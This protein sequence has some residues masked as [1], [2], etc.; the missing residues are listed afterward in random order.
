[1]DRNLTYSQIVKH[2]TKQDG[3]K[4]FLMSLNGDFKKISDEYKLDAKSEIIGIIRKYKLLSSH[5][6]QHYIH[7][8]EN[9][10]GY[11]TV[12][13]SSR[14]HETPPQ[15]RNTENLQGFS[16]IC[17]CN[18]SPPATENNMSVGSPASALSSTSRDTIFSNI[19]DNTLQD[20]ILKTGIRGVIG[21]RKCLLQCNS[22]SFFC[23]YTPPYNCIKVL[24]FVS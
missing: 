2:S 24:D 5:R 7:P 20:S 13:F 23:R 11:N 1:V 14:H 18:I 6:Q 22:K 17:C 15:S 4:L 16:N 21:L 12:S 19:L 8:Q 9:Y 10:T 3:D